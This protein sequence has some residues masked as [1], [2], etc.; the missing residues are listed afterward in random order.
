MSK[1]LNFDNTVKK[2][3][4]VS[5]KVEIIMRN[6]LIIAFFLIVDGITF[7][8][9]PDTT[10]SEMA[11]NIILLILL[12][13]FSVFITNLSAKTKDL[14]TIIT[15]IIIIILGAIFY[16]YPDFI[17]GYMQL[18]LALFII[19]NG[20]VNIANALNFS[21][22]LSKYTDAISKKYHK[23]FGRKPKNKKRQQQEE[24]F[25][26]VDNNINQGLEEQ[27]EKLVSP[28]RNILSKASK[29]SVLFIIANTA[30]IILGLVLLVLPDVSMMVWG[31]I[32]IYTGLP[33]LFAAI[34]TMHLFK[35]IKERKFKEI[36]FD[37][38]QDDKQK[39]SK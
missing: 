36:L 37:A 34:K 2:V 11:K 7:I 1:K 33:N 6:R 27:K 12:A 9:N 21:D 35:K 18:L 5:S 23:L 26:E 3:E 20:L 17:A 38:E 16:F 31:I 8:L 25:K 24:K 13:A 10:L 14:K 29:H 39:P 4:G 32:F 15:S 22:K 30:S 28:L 19:Y